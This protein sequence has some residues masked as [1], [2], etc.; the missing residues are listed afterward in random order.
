MAEPHTGQ[1]VCPFSLASGQLSLAICFFI[2]LIS[3][4]M[5]KQIGH[6]GRPSLVLSGS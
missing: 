5:S 4:K 1:A 2:A 3:S 6:S